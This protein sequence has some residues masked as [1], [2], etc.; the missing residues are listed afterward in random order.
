LDLAVNS[1]TIKLK[2]GRHVVLKEF[3]IED[4]DGLVKMYASLSNEALRWGLPPY[5][6]ERIERW[7]SNLQHLIAMVALD[8][9][10]IIGHAQISKFAHPRRRG[11]A[12]LL[13]YLHQDF[14]GVGLGSAMLARLLELARRDGLHRLNL[15]VVAENKAAVRLYE[16]FGFKIEGAKK[17]AYLGE[18]GRYHD[19]FVMGLILGNL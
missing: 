12:D 5:T 7:L 19:E 9:D 1:E 6:Q 18:D 15:D 8:G 14:H 4:K 3:L 2:D 16:K 13:I 17:E 11:T 10:R